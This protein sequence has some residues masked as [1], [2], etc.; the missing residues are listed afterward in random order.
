MPSKAAYFVRGSPCANVATFPESKAAFFVRGSVRESLCSDVRRSRGLR[1]SAGSGLRRSRAL[2]ANL[3][4]SGSHLDSCSHLDSFS[5]VDPVF[6]Y[7][8]HGGDTRRG[9][10][11][12]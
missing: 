6:S 5:Y 9:A 7:V 12:G 11:P 4:R 10:R 3:C 2:R 1:P 8:D